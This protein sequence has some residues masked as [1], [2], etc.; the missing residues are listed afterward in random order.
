MV[1]ESMMIMLSRKGVVG[2]L[3]Y[4]S[5][6]SGAYHRQSPEFAMERQRNIVELTENIAVFVCLLMLTG[7]EPVI[8][9]L[10]EAIS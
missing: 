2:G 5:Q 10:E 4:V 8:S 3:H 6:T 7:S 9:Q 1:G